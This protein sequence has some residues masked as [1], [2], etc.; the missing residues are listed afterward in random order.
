MPTHLGLLKDRL[1]ALAASG[2][3]K[4][5][6]YAV[7]RV[8]WELSGSS[9]TVQTSPCEFFLDRIGCIER[10]SQWSNGSTDEPNNWSRQAVVYDLFVRAATA[11]DHNED[12]RIDTSPIGSGWRETGTL[13]KSIALLPYIRNLGFN[14]IH[15][16][17]VSE[18]GTDARKGNL[19]SPYSVRD[20][21][22]IDPGL[23][24]PALR[25]SPET[26]LAA[27][28]EAAHWLGVRVIVEFALRT[29]AKD[30]RQVGEHPEW[31][32]WIRAD[33]PDR[34]PG[35]RDEAA[36]G[37]PLFSPEELQTIEARAAL[38]DHSDLPVPH[39]I[40]RQMFVAP[41]P[42]KSV[43]VQ[44][45]GWQVR[46]DHD[47]PA[48]IPSAFADWPPDDP[49]P[50]WTD[51]TYLRLYNHPEF[52]YIAYNTVRMYD[53][54]LARPENAL[55]TLWDY[56]SSVIPAHQDSFDIDGA[57]LDM[58]HALP[59]DLKAQVITAAR[60]RDP[61]FAFWVEDFSVST[62]S[63]DAGY[64]AAVGS[65][66]WSAYR[67]ER[68]VTDVLEICAQH[69]HVMPFLAA[70]ETHD[71]PRAAGRPGGLAYARLVWVL[72]CLLPAIPF[73][74]AG[75]EIGETVPVNT[76]L[77]FQPDEAAS[78]PA[79]R[80]PLFSAAAYRWDDPCPLAESLK[81]ALAFRSRFSSVVT[82]PDPMTFDLLQTANP[83]VA[84]IL[85]RSERAAVVGIFNLDWQAPQSAHLLLPTMKAVLI[86]ILS[87]RT[88]RLHQGM[89]DV[90]LRPADCILSE[91]RT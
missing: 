79:G 22:R 57:M 14:T 29:A 34:P 56:I 77:D 63:R 80:L 50:P 55:T 90:Q 78:Y 68:L 46:S 7:P 74:Q 11:F 52:N 36:Y 86:D 84:A 25:L 60:A 73:C 32:Y 72:G 2:A 48:R 70:P 23:A 58:G 71:T 31:F 65:Y 37:P 45:G 42:R 40:F 43:F 20:P 4:C 66:W 41:P 83:S 88:W 9:G 27:F 26:Q 67:P 44:D 51:V 82:N 33:I 53:E 15:L 19:G 89:L 10:Q 28:V 13:L 3:C 18:I 47:T 49:Q 85:R 69:G 16:L 81:R 5:V 54:R 12:G 61:N 6:P 75:F 24:E 17:P 1:E 39:S 21:L 91:L 62:E 38:S 59:R 30:A 64:D 35:S 8:W 76:G 87:E